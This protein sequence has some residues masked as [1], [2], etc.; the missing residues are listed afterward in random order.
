MAE[1]IMKDV[2]I[3]FGAPSLEWK[4]IVLTKHGAENVDLQKK[5]TPRTNSR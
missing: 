3:N 5:T 2:L 4:R 1:L